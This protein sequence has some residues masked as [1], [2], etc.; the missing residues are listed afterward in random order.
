M[1]GVGSI[2]PYIYAVGLFP[3]VLVTWLIN[4]SHGQSI[5]HPSGWKQGCRKASLEEEDPETRK[6]E[7]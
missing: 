7:I 6:I 2:T 4:Q 5:A 1:T 3:V